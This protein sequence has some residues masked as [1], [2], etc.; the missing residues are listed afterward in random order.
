[1]FIIR[2]ASKWSA[3]VCVHSDRVLAEGRKKTLQ[4]KLRIYCLPKTPR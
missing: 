1:M 4:T 2:M 3:R